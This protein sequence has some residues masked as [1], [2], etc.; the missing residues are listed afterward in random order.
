MQ[1]IPEEYRSQQLTVICPV[2]QLPIATGIQLTAV[3]LATS[4]FTNVRVQCPHC[5]SEHRWSTKDAFLV[6]SDS[7][8]LPPESF[9]F[10]RRQPPNAS[11]RR[12]DPAP[13]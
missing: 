4:I 11:K 3:A 13:A 8:L 1:Q 6:A 5:E 9:T 10:G 2:T 12:P 7:G